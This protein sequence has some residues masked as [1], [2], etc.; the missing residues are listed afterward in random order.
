MTL[1]LLVAGESVSRS[2]GAPAVCLFLPDGAEPPRETLLSILEHTPAEVPLLLVGHEATVLEDLAL[3]AGDET[4]PLELLGLV[5]APGTGFAAA[6]N[7]ASGAIG[8]GDVALV[9][10]GVRVGTQWLRC[11]EQA[12][13]SDSTVCSATAL[14]DG[15]GPLG[16]SIGLERGGS[17]ATTR[18]DAALLL[19]SDSPRIR[20]RI[21]A[22]GPHCVYLRRELFDRLGGLDVSIGGTAAAL[23]EF[24]LRAL[25]AGMLHVA[26]DDVLVQCATDPMPLEGELQRSETDDRS[27]ALSRALACAR[28]VVRGISV[29]IDARALGPAMGGTQLYTTEL[30]LALAREE[31]LHVRAV[32]PPDLPDE[33]RGRFAAVPGLEL[34]SYEQAVS[35]VEPSDIVHRPQQVFSEDDLA[36]LKLLG[37]RV[38]IGQ[39]DLISYRNPAYHP[40]VATW[41]AYRRVTRLALAVADR[42]VFFSGHARADALEEG[43][44]APERAAVVGIGG[45]VTGATAVSPAPVDGVPGD[46]DLLVCVGADYG[47]KNR[48]FAILLLRALRDRHAWPGML[49]LAGSHVPHGSSRDEEL[50][51]LQAH[52]ALAEA[53]ID[54]GSVS[55]SGK[56]WLYS[57]A[58]AV[59]YPRL[60]EGFGLIPF[61]AARA[62]TPCLY[63]PQASLAEL[64]GPEAATLIP[65]NAELSA[66]ACSALLADGPERPRHLD[67]LNARWPAA[68]GR[69]RR[70]DVRDLPRRVPLALSGRRAAGMAGARA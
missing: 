24:S 46:R 29:T 58:R 10:P 47:H 59:L 64:A 33:L 13:H 62:G 65:W 7:A 32:V 35:G 57:R 70:A 36:L 42:V 49:V 3:L 68:Q 37:E 1:S 20:P 34:L 15:S 14:H 69:R 60:Y 51:I 53:V 8:D 43:L 56:A 11:L 31:R 54:V 50:R 22:A 27:S 19:A 2:R 38:V 48:P 25:S 44:T 40:D 16:L 41:R 23:C 17:R 39:Q 55:E 52:P 66:D 12:A 61:E 63:A 45:E 26:A 21:P 4:R 28:S 18:P 6:V 5:L 30:I 9:A 67:L